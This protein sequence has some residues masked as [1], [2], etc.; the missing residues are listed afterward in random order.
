MQFNEEETAK[1]KAMLGFLIKK[2]HRESNGKC[3]FHIMELQPL[4][5]DM[6]AEGVITKRP[7]INNSQYFINP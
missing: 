3:G 6:V 1:L 5:D 7:T 2:K 4:L